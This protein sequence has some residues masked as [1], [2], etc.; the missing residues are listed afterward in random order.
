MQYVHQ[1]NEKIPALGY[2]T[3]ELRG[4]GCVKGVKA[5]LDVGY[6]HIDTA[7]I[8]GNEEFVGQALSE[9]S[10]AR[11]DVFLTTKIWM[12]NFPKARFMAS[13]DESLKKLQTDY[14]NLLLL[15][16][17]SKDHDFDTTLDLLV[18]AKK[19]GKA[20]LIGVSN[21]TIDMMDRA[22]KKTG[23]L[24]V[25][26]QVEY[27]PFI[28]QGPVLEW[29]RR[30]GHMFLTAYSPLGR[31]NVG[32]NQIIAQIANKYKKNAGQIA[33]RWEIQQGVVA[34]PKAA[35]QKNIEGNF[36]IFDFEL[37]QEDM[38]KISA[39]ASADGRIVNPDFA[40]DWDVGKA[41]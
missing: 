10:V 3:W 8:Y 37:A 36:D 41:A 2:G 21:Y 15:H 39:L 13:L 9:H 20:H 26:N 31:G 25:T 4:E 1:Q 17:P 6:R 19:S 27:H 35:S 22:Q 18:E 33:L 24:L 16:W 30:N 12:D 34:I 7:Q 29:I 14:V 5:A 11:Q 23:N 28:D 32:N 38:D 40:P